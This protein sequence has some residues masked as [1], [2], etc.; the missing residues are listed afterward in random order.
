MTVG[1]LIRKL[2]SHDP[3]T[4]VVLNGYEGGIEDAS[5]VSGIKL[6][7]NVN[8][9]WYYGK[10]EKDEDGECEAILIS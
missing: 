8:T 6:R 10:H 4:R 5:S 2:E 9:E 7:L 3:D 1:E